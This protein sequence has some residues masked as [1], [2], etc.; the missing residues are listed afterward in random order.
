MKAI[1]VRQAQRELKRRS[2]PKFVLQEQGRS[3]EAGLIL[4]AFKQQQQEGLIA[5]WLA[6]ITF[7]AIIPSNAGASTVTGS[8]FSVAT[9][10]E[11]I[12]VLYSVGTVG[13]GTIS[14]QAQSCSS[15]GGANPASAGAAFGTAAG[16]GQ[17]ELDMETFANTFIRAVITI[18]TGPT[19]IAVIGIGQ[20]K[21]V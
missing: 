20:N 9:I 7:L 1:K 14:C 21:L 5:S 10:T 16:N 12:G 19:P 6:G 11:K 3:P 13:G 4:T 2:N 18:V 17:F 15:T 8:G